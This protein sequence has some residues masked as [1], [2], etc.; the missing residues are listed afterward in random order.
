MP[1]N[2]DPDNIKQ[3]SVVHQELKIP[4]T[5]GNFIVTKYDAYINGVKLSDKAIS[6]DDYSSDDERIIHLILYKRSGNRCKTAE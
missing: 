2:W 5:F 4:R 6:I 1:F 3:V